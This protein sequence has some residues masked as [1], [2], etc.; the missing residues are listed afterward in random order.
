MTSKSPTTEYFQKYKSLLIVSVPRSASTALEKACFR[1]LIPLKFK[2]KGEILN[3]GYQCKLRVPQYTKK[4][5]DF[6]KLKEQCLRFTQNNII[7]DV[8]QPHF[9]VQYLN[10]ITDRFNVIFLLRSLDGIMTSRKRLGWKMPRKTV[11]R[12]Q[13]MLRDIPEREGYKHIDYYDFIR[14][15]PYKLIKILQNWYPGCQHFEYMTKDFVKKRQKTLKILK[16]E[17]ISSKNK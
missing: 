6:E 10:W 3:S 12:Y 17:G 16:F 9:F 5:K 8:V 1:G 15:D 11:L 2:S 13:N 14:D 4:E 7:R